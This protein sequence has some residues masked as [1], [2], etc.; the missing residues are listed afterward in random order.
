MSIKNNK[1][2]N[3]KQIIFV[4]DF[5]KNRRR[6]QFI[7]YFIFHIEMIILNKNNWKNWEKFI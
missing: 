7:K 6:N 4:T 1:F 5:I 3:K 2:V